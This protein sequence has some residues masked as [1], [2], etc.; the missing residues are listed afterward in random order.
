MAT[1]EPRIS[2]SE[3]GE[4]SPRLGLPGP[5]PHSQGTQD[6]GT[7]EHDNADEQQVQ[8]ALDDDAHE[9]EDDRHDHEE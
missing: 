4:R 7:K 8:Q 5:T 3:L 2:A 9:A 6:K 1:R